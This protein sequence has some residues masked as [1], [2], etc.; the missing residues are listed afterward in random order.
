MSAYTTVGILD[1]ARYFH[2]QLHGFY[3]GLKSR[4][5]QEKLLLILDY[6]AQH[7][8]RMEQALQRYEQD[9]AHKVAETWFKY[10]PEMS[11]DEAIAS[12]A[13]PRTMSLDDLMTIA[14]KL[15]NYFVTLYQ[16]AAEQ[17]VSPDVK[18]VF[19]QLT[20]ETMKDRTKL[21]RDLVDMQDL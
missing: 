21:S 13:L 18:E 6:L 16:R 1:R 19:E 10:N 17:A 15:E 12:I 8:L 14:I 2:K 9:I 7:E 4:I 20:K 3:D 5:E 11:I